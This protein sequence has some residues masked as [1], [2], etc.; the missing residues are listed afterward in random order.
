[1][2]PVLLDH[3]SD[4]GRAGRA[5]E[6][7]WGLCGAFAWV[8]DGATGLG[9]RPLLD[10]ESDAAWLTAVVSEALAEGAET[11]DD[12]GALLSH[13]AR[14]AERRFVA[15]RVR[16]P[17]ERYEIPTAAILL[18]RFD[19]VGVTAVDLGDCGMYLEENGGVRRIGG[20]DAG[21]E[22]EKT[23]AQRLMAGGGGRSADVVAFLREVR[24]RANT[25]AG[26]AILAPDAD[27]AT[28]A[29]RNFL[30]FRAGT[31]LLLTDGF[32]AA[33]EDYALHSPESLLAAADRLGDTLKAL[34]EVERNDPACTRFP[35]FKPSDDA[36]ALTLRVTPGGGRA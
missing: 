33:V 11:A 13:A 19:E 4:P 35:R 27:S 3:V 1:L 26:Y 18:A 28:R 16:A 12:P 31:A 5:N 21:R 2:T 23:N 32:E 29:R 36:T 34:R 9:E 10:A 15:E 8:I 30:P 20:T 6:D 7:G 24:G 22:L 14:V 25:P 17:E